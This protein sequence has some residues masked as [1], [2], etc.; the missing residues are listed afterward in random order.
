MYDGG[1]GCYSTM[2]VIWL[3]ELV[4][5]SWIATENEVSVLYVLP[6]HGFAKESVG[7]FGSWDETGIRVRICHA[8]IPLDRLCRFVFLMIVSREVRF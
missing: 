1:F 8:Y 3:V 6:L 4:L 7:S 5:C 2:W